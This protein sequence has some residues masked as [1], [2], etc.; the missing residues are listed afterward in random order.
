M[1][2][3]GFVFRVLFLVLRIFSERIME[4]FRF[5]H[6]FVRHSCGNFLK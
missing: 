3:F 6:G 4:L 5:I 1:N 2:V